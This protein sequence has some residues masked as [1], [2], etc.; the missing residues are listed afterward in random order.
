M[1]LVVLVYPVSSQPGQA[2]QDFVEITVR[3]TLQLLFTHKNRKR[4][5]NYLLLQAN[6]CSVASSPVVHH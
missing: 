1:A 5:Q 4:R 2:I 6:S 3:T